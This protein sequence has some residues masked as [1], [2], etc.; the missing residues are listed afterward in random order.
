MNVS[1]L[2]RR[3][4]KILMGGRE[5]EELGRKK[6]GVR[7]I[8]RGRMQYGRKQGCYTEGQETKVMCVAMWDG[9]LAVPTSNFQ[10]L[11][12]QEAPRTQGAWD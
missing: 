3:G 6:G 4:N 5:W 7:G 9:E 8:K 1:D 10:M 2:L 12:K 11:G